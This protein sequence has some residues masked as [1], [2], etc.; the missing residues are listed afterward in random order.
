M[1]QFFVD[2][3]IEVGQTIMLSSDQEH[4]AKNV[5]RLHNEIVRVVSNEGGYFGNGY[6]EENHFLIHIKEKDVSQKELPKDVTLAI[7]LI[8]REKLELVLQKA[9]ELGVKTI[10]PFISSRCVVQEKKEKSSRQLE[11]WNKI[12]KEASAQ[13]K[14]NVIP[15]IKDIQSI[16]EICRYTVPFKFIANSD[17]EKPSP[18][19]EDV[20]K[21]EETLIVIGPEGGFSTKEIALFETNQFTSVSLGNRILRAETACLYALSVIA[22]FQERESK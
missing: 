4:H 11:R 13:C 22:S 6:V 16:E 18:L 21:S 2:E 9:T 15:I 8:R 3:K 19:L 14:R 1:Y 5:L 12:V 10:I 17:L 7:A 20:L